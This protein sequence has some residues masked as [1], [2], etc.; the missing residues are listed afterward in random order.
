MSHEGLQWTIAYGSNLDP[1]QLKRRIGDVART[2]VGHLPGY[3]L[4]FDKVS[5]WAPEETYAN[6]VPDPASS[7][8]AVAFLFDP[9]QVGVMDTYEG[10]PTHYV[11]E[12]IDFVPA[13]QGEEPRRAQ[14]WIATPAWRYSSDSSCKVS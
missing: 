12:E 9:R 6:I 1:I 2:V 13:E 3:R 14:A 7:C 10:A 4:V 5:Q 11:R 8:P